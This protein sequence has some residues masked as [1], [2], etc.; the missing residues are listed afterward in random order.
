MKSKEWPNIYVFTKAVAESVIKEEGKGLP[1]A[2]VRPSIGNYICIYCAILL[3]YY[4]K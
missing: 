1:V 2:V 3:T 4:R